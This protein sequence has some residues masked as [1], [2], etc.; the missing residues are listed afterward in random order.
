MSFKATIY[1]IIFSPSKIYREQAVNF[2]REITMD[3]CQLKKTCAIWNMVYF[4]NSHDDQLPLSMTLTLNNWSASFGVIAGES[5]NSWLVNSSEKLLVS[6]SLAMIGT[7]GGGTFFWANFSQSI[8]YKTGIT[9]H[10]SILQCLNTSCTLN[11]GWDWTS[12]APCLEPSRDSGSLM[13]NELIRCLQFGLKYEGT[14]GEDLTMCLWAE[15]SP[16]MLKCFSDVQ[17]F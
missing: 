15:P 13:S 17:T 11:Q 12:D 14:L 5:D 8:V 7:N 16:S 9:H 10:E 3:T 1:Q 4:Q 2:D 6:I